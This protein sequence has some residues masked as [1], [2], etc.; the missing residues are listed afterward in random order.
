MDLETP[1]AVTPQISDKANKKIQWYDRIIK[2]WFGIGLA[3]LIVFS[4]LFQYNHPWFV[5]DMM[6]DNNLLGT[7]GDFV[8]GVLGTF[9]TFYGMILMIHTFQ[10]QIESNDLTQTTNQKLLGT[11]LQNS[12][13][14]FEQYKL[15]KT[16][17]FDSQFN[18]FLILYNNAVETY[19]SPDGKLKGREYLDKLVESFL[20]ENFTNNATYG[21]RVDA[22][23][24]LYEE[25]Y[26][27]NRE[28]MSTHFRMLYQLVHFI[29]NAQYIDNEMKVNYVK[30]IRGS[31]NEAEMIFLRYNCL[32]PFGRKMQ[33]HVNEFNMLKHL[34]IMKLFEL[35]KW[36]DL[37][38]SP[39][40]TTALNTMFIE[41][42]KRI[43]IVL[44]DSSHNV[45]TETM[46][47]GKQW[48]IT[49]TF[50]AADNTLLVKIQKDIKNSRRGTAILNIEKA[51]EILDIDN[52][53]GL[54]YD[55]FRELFFISNF[56]VYNRKDRIRIS[57][58]R[59]RNKNISKIRFMFRSDYPL[60]VSQRQISSPQEQTQ[61]TN[62][63]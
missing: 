40:Q 18:S 56:N 15:Q 47:Y 38:E 33:Q 42:R 39:K 11:T 21:K 10:N 1:I 9:L 3:F 28:K 31:M 13:L 61:T 41:L 51:F 57:H 2:Y 63:N 45:R 24:K 17:L 30:A 5:L 16:Q 44:L 12:K 60:I 34:P 62:L 8:G 53:E 22:A 58:C 27:T 23:T 43:C 20:N 52:L 29:S 36:A 50:R 7:F 54:F 55:Y 37:I 19:R 14:V 48:S 46:A 4:I 6:I 25:F 35:K 26:A 59:K 49:V 32:C